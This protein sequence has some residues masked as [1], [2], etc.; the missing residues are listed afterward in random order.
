MAMLHKFYTDENHELSGSCL[1][2]RIRWH[3]RG[4]F[5]HV[6]ACHCRECRKWSGHFFPGIR[7]R[8]ERI[9]IKREEAL[10]WYRSSE[11]A[12]RGFCG[13][14]G[15]SLFWQ[16]GSITNIAAGS[17]DGETGFGIIQHIH[18]GEAG[19]YYQL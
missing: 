18:T 4:P 16:S 17:V 14:C 8:S 6:V 9:V 1:C 3:A 15:S 13:E 2:G 19:D 5:R 10:R 11:F 12:R 7:C